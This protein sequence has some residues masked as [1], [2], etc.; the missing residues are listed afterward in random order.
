MAL[1]RPDGLSDEEERNIVRCTLRR[2]VELGRIRETKADVL[3]RLLG[4]ADHLRT[5]NEKPEARRAARAALRANP[6]LSDRE[7][8]R[9]YGLHRTDVAEIRKDVDWEREK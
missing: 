3:L 8:S 1:R 9:R 4:G 7:L 5:E 2:E 6:E